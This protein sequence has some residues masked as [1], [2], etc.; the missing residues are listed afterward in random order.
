MKRC[1]YCGAVIEENARFCLYCMKELEGKVE[2]NARPVLSR[3]TIWLAALSACF[4]VA[5]ICAVIFIG[6][7]TDT[8]FLTAKS[9]SEEIAAFKQDSSQADSSSEQDS[10]QAVT[11]K[12]QNETTDVNSVVDKLNNSSRYEAQI[13]GVKYIY[14][15][16]RSS[17]YYFVK[18]DCTGDIV[19]TGIEGSIKSGVYNIPSEIDG[20]RVVSIAGYAFK[21]SNAKAVY[22]P[23]GIKTIQSFAF[24][25]CDNITDIYF[26]G[27]SINT[28]MTAFSAKN[29][30]IHCS[31]KCHDGTYWYYRDIASDYGA[32][33]EEWN[34]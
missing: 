22:F 8:Q 25:N 32:T 16:A 30:V 23:D 10:S 4:T 24:Y 28:S 20:K 14:R 19:I 13:D 7:D 2:V 6:G 31:S 33:Y 1:P 5:V 3:K 21:D 11:S 18:V 26:R 27:T 15:D 29:F 12:G 17:D 34:G 9:S